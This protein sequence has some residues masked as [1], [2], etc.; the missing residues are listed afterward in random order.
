MSAPVVAVTVL[1]DRAQVTRRG[2]VPVAAGQ[3]RVVIEG[4]SPVLV[5]KTLLC[6]AT[7]ARVLDARCERYVAPWRDPDGTSTELVARLHAE[8][9]SARAER[10]AAESRA[11]AATSESSA[12]DELLGAALTDLAVAAT[13]G[14]TPPDA[15]A[16]LA[17]LDA[18]GAAARVRRVEA[19]L[20]VR[21][22]SASFTRLEERLRRAL[23]QA[24]DDAARIVIDLV[25]DA[26]GEATL[27]CRYVVPGAAWRPYHRAQLAAGTVIWETTACVWQA[28]GEDWP[29]AELTF[30]L[31]RPSLGIAPPDLADDELRARRR[32]ET[33]TVEARDH[34]QQT[35][36]LGTSGP[37]EVPGIDDGGLGLVLR[38]TS[39]VS[40]RADGAPH[41]VPVGSWTSPAE[42]ALIAIPLRSPWVHLRARLANAGP[43]PILAG[44]VDLILAAGYV[45]RAEVGFV[46]SGER[47]DLGFGPEAD[48]RIHRDEVSTREDGGILGGWNQ[49]TVRVALRLSSLGDT[50]REVT[51]TERVPVSEVEQ[52][53]V[54]TSP[55]DA[56]SIEE[57]GTVQVTAREIDDKGLVTW[58]VPLP[59]QARRVVTLEYR[60]RSKPGVAGV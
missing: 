49:K 42:L 37:R 53:E 31:E 59:P 36:G 35:T 26:A 19:E 58:L 8:R 33:V 45:G 3:Q 39:R 32:P 41:R 9:I 15:A 7:G 50:A 48:V 29:A 2:P 11:V 14:T 44:P 1:E 60:I 24:G 5:D 4:V 57:R 47:V 43:A 18:A 22:A 17:E 13:R 16:R 12:L 30:S 10:A 25:A 20:A 40:V 27:D 21:D 54:I 28:T 23:A 34:E 51:V 6:V 55:A 52:V 46:A 56:Y 38:G